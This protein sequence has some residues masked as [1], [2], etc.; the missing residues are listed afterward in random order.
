MFAPLTYT[1]ML[2]SFSSRVRERERER[3]RES[4]A[5]GPFNFA[6]LEPDR[7]PPSGGG[8]PVGGKG[9]LPDCGPLGDLLTYL[10]H[11]YFDG[12]LFNRP[13]IGRTEGEAQP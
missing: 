8:P 10:N 6:P 13:G 9:I 11:V 12:K 4:L 3:E 5:Q 2:H 1:P 7:G